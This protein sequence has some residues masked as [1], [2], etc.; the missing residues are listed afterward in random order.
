MNCLMDTIGYTHGRFQPL[1]NG[2]F[3]I[4][5]YILNKCKFLWI[6]ITNPERVLPPDIDKLD[7]KLRASLIRA[8]DPKNNPYNFEERKEMIRSSLSK[9]GIDMSRIKITP[10]YGFYDREDWRDFMPPKENSIIFLAA[11]DSHHDVKI[12]LY[13]KEGWK[14]EVLSLFSGFSGKLFDKEWPNGNWESLVP[15]GT[16]EFLESKLKKS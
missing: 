2:H 10:H 7:E 6:G 12:Q 1:H 15:K 16:A 8:R 9:E 13:K 11:K 3:K 14:V 4:F 5:L